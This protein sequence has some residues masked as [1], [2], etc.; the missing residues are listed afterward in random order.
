MHVLF[1]TSNGLYELVHCGVF[2]SF[3]LVVNALSSNHILLSCIIT[4][5]LLSLASVTFC[6]SIITSSLYLTWSVNIKAGKLYLLFSFVYSRALD[7]P[8]K[9]VLLFD[10][11][12][13]E[14]SFERIGNNNFIWHGL[15]IT[16]TVNSGLVA[17]DHLFLQATIKVLQSKQNEHFG[18][19]K[20]DFFCLSK[21]F[22]IASIVDYVKICNTK[23][24]SEWDIFWDLV[25]CNYCIVWRGLVEFNKELKTMATIH[26]LLA[27][28][29]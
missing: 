26:V 11:P 15:F 29:F 23:L 4:R 5:I 28:D 3:Y 16:L 19:T 13:V 12:D 6:L 22:T 21:R 7:G 24:L 27:H 1:L 10:S 2:L 25:V 20:R 17:R 18:F 9:H 8:M 14:T